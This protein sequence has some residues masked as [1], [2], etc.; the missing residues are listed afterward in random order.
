[1]K[2]MLNLI[3]EDLVLTEKLK[4]KEAAKAAKKSG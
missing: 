3:E 2:K 1:M 4:I